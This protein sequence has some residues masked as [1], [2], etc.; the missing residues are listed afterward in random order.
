MHVRTATLGHNIQLHQ[1]Y[2][3]VLILFGSPHMEGK[4]ASILQALREEMPEDA[5]VLFYSAYKG[6]PAPCLDCGYCERQ[7]GCSQ[8]DLDAFMR[9]FE[10]CDVFVVATPV[11]YNSFPA[12][13]KAV[14][15]RFQ[16]YFSARFV[17]LV[18]PPVKKPKVA[19]LIATCGSDE[20]AGLYNV[21]SQLKRAV[22][23]L[24]ATLAGTVFAKGT[25]KTEISDQVYAQAHKL[26][27]KVFARW[28]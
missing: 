15:D 25:D 10:D 3:K 7:E 1:T 21:K 16:R 20:R 8:H 12:P 18:R 13:L 22:T 28:L 27:K 19:V 23:V 11:Y 6:K 4:T 5:Q 26:G 9:A 14:I 17:R 2:P 24:N